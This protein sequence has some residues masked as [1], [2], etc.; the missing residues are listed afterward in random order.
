MTTV[1]ILTCAN[2]LHALVIERR[3]T[4]RFGTTCG[5]VE[6]DAFAEHPMGLTWST[7]ADFAPRLPVSGGL[8][9]AIS[10]IDVIWYRRA[11]MPQ[12]ASKEVS[13]QA[14]A[15]VINYSCTA[16]LM[17]LL[18][19]HFRGRWVSDPEAT[20]A[21]ENKLVQLDAARAAGMRVPRTLTSQDPAAIKAFCDEMDGKVVMKSL[22]AAR[23]RHLLTV[24]VSPEIHQH[25]DNL[26]LCP[27]IFQEFVPGTRHLRV[28]ACGDATVAFAIDSADL[29]W[30]SNLD[31]PVSV[32]TLDPETR[33]QILQVMS[34]LRLR[35]GVFDLKV[36]D[37]GPVWLEVNPQ[38]QFLFL[39]GMSGADLTTIFAEFLR[40]EASAVM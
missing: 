18:T 16:T 20:R 6:V 27:T 12:L 24:E 39:E 33:R 5:I 36:D 11:Y 13:K 8:E 40:A 37:D 28:L 2:D 19:N 22:R 23:D 9:L 32:V 1:A 3:L 14:V 21:A 35:M 30:R 4:E 26:R 38:G 34:T 15:D 17:G 10:E 31:V 29:D 7:S 25:P